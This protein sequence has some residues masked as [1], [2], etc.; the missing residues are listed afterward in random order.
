MVGRG[1]IERARRW[2]IEDTK[3]EKQRREERGG[4][5]ERGRGISL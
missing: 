1:I 5:E 3:G 2:E 4:V